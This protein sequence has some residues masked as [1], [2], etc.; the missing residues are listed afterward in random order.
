MRALSRAYAVELLRRNPTVNTYLGGAGLDASLREVDGRLGV[1]HTLEDAA[2][3][4]RAL[5]PLTRKLVAER[6][7]QRQSAAAA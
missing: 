3:Y 4:G 5:I 2:D 1:A 6:D 7:K